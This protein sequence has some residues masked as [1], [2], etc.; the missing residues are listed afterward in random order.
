[1]NLWIT[2]CGFV[3]DSNKH[4]TH[5]LFGKSLFESNTNILYS[6]KQYPR[7]ET[8]CT[9]YY[10][11]SSATVLTSLNFIYVEFDYYFSYFVSNIYNRKMC[12]YN[13]FVYNLY[14]ELKE[15]EIWNRLNSKKD[16]Y[17]ILDFYGNMIFLK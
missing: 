7:W 16:D 11:L 13:S 8:S 9:F 6:N 17:Y 4:K 15:K 1:M 14:H 12:W 2:Y 3:F 5:N 10:F